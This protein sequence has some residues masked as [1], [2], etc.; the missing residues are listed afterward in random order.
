MRILSISSTLLVAVLVTTGASIA[1]TDNSNSTIPELLRFA[2][3]YENPAEKH[4]ERNSAPVV[5]KSDPEITA[6]RSQ[7]SRQK[8]TI[9]RMRTEMTSLRKQAASAS[10]FAEKHNETDARLSASQ[11]ELTR[12]RQEMQS[13]LR[14]KDTRVA[15]LEKQRILDM[16]TLTLSRQE[17]DA[18]KREAS[19]ATQQLKQQLEKSAKQD[20]AA[21]QKR[22]AQVQK[23]ANEQTEELTR[24]RKLVTSRDTASK[25][26]RSDGSIVN[27]NTPAARQAYVSGMSLGKDMVSLNQGDT[28][29]GM[30]VADPAVVIAGL[31]DVLTGQVLMD[32]QAVE[33]T[34]SERETLVLN[35]VKTT[36]DRQKKEAATWLADFRKQPGVKQTT[37]G[38]W[39]RIDYEGDTEILAGDPVVDI[40]VRE[41]LTDG[42]TVNDMELTGSV[43]SMKLSEY[44][45]VFREAIRMLRQHGRMTIAVPPD[46]AYGDRGM[47]PSIPPGATMIYTI[48]LESS[49]EGTSTRNI[50]DPD[51]S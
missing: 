6:L 43:L 25:I 42:T 3:E 11:K 35:A 5:R 9:E 39:Y 50:I 19:G 46:R 37:S 31:R 16:K 21:I 24:L 48:Q 4:K 44:P 10:A 51:K 34:H 1:A 29:L 30:P 20:H 49:V 36:I 28:V 26:S 7:L 13:S 8:Q 15:A 17:I 47:P 14:E 27:L 22:L 12:V 18:L 23:R 41:D 38:L 45:P 33:K 40:A 2:R 32:K